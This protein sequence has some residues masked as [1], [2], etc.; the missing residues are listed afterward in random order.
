MNISILHRP[1]RH[2]AVPFDEPPPGDAKRVGGY[3]RS[4]PRAA[5]AAHG[6]RVRSHGATCVRYR[7]RRPIEV[8]ERLDQ[9]V[10]A[11]DGLAVVAAR[12]EMSRFLSLAVAH[13]G[14][15]RA[16]APATP[17]AVLLMADERERHPLWSEFGPLPL[18]RQMLALAL[19]SLVVLLAISIDAT[20]N[21]EIWPNRC[22]SCRGFPCSWSRAFLSRPRLSAPALPICRES[23]P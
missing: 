15:A 11:A 14:L 8:M 3:W 17:E 22:S 20:V 19:L 23:T 4:G 16:I 5:V 7:P 12:D 6:A 2:A 13:A 10:S 9:A 18:V 21:T 1:L